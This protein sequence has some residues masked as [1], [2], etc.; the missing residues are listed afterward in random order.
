[1]DALDP[2]TIHFGTS[3]SL[4]FPRKYWCLKFP[5]MASWWQEKKK[6]KSGLPSSLPFSMH[7]F[8]KE[9]LSPPSLEALKKT[10][11]LVFLGYVPQ[12]K[13]FF[14]VV[15][16]EEEEVEDDTTWTPTEEVFSWFHFFGFSSHDD[17]YETLCDYVK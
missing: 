14:F 6:Q 5:V 17:V 15:K 10:M 9:E 13:N 16:E 7:L 1:M 8:P 2:F 12:T 4:T 3:L 11:D